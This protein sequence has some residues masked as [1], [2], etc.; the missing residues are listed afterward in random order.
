MYCKVLEY[1]SQ[2][3]YLKYMSSAIYIHKLNIPH[4]R[5]YLFKITMNNYNCIIV[6]SEYENNKSTNYCSI[7]VNR[8]A[9]S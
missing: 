7:V 1:I 9:N 4:M 8:F 2:N 5:N 3:V 6:S